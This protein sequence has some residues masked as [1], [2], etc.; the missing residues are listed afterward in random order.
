MEISKM[1][2]PPLIFYSD[3]LQIDFLIKLFGIFFGNIFG[4]KIKILDGVGRIHPQT[5]SKNNKQ[6]PEIPIKSIL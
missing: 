2:F 3:P 5:K 6:T 1:Y 4:R